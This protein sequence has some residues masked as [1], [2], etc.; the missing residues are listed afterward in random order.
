MHIFK[1][2]DS[3][4]LGAWDLYDE[5]DRPRDVTI[6]IDRVERKEIRSQRGVDA[7]PVIW[8]KGQKKPMVCNKTNAKTIVNLY[9]PD[10][11]TWPGKRITLYPTTT[12]NS[13][14]EVA[15]IR[16]RPKIPPGRPVTQQRPPAPEPAPQFDEEHGD[17]DE[18]E[19]QA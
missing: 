1:M 9:G 4:Y 12:N 6:T 14:G 17:A 18:P 10:V 13:D 7:K 15:C 16:V 2:F 11:A 3:E 8:F 5:N 19:A